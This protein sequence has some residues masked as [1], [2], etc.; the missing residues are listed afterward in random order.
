MPV[1]DWRHFTERFRAEMMQEE[2][3][4]IVDSSGDAIIGTS[5]EGRITSWNKAAAAMF[6]YTSHEAVGQSMQ[7]L[8]PQ[9]RVQEEMDLLAQVRGGRP[10]H[11]VETVRLRQDGNHIPVS[12][13]ISPIFNAGSL[14]TGISM[15]ARDI[16]ERRHMSE[17]ALRQERERANEA[18][19]RSALI[20]RSI[21]TFFIQLDT[22]NTI[23]EWNAAAE[24]IFSLSASETVG[25]R[26]TDLPIQWEW[27]VG[28]SDRLPSRR[29]TFRSFTIDCVPVVVPVNRRI[30][31]RV[32]ITTLPSST[33]PIVVMMGED[34]TDRLRVEAEMAQTQKLE[35]IGKLAAGIAH[36]INTPTQYIGDNT[37]FLQDSF[38]QLT[39]VLQQYH[40][41]IMV[42]KDRE[43]ASDI[44]V[45]LESA[46]EKADLK[47]MLEEIPKAIQQS[48]EGIERVA[49]I[50]RAMKEFAHPDQGQRT[51]TDLNKAIQ[52]TI[53]VARNEWKYVADVA[54]DL[55]P[56]LPLVPC[57]VGEFNQVILNLIVNAT[58]AIV[59][60]RTSGK[61]TITVTTRSRPS[62][63]EVRIQDTGTGIP[64]DIR[65]K[66]FD[67]FFTTKEVGKG[68]GQGLAIARSVIV[69]KHG[70]SLTFET[71]LGVGTTFVVSLPTDADSP[72][73]SS[74]SEAHEIHHAG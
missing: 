36:E 10:V 35:S 48:L 67:P 9:E 41:V 40:S 44:I 73:R 23:L 11:D 47:Y 22:T 18:G 1:E 30:V 59:D 39:V 4:A 74:M 3:A 31:L 50:V 5:L 46:L 16:T 21:D 13:T 55:E 62:S 32:S 57:Y 51:L 7:L 29:G 54:V 43:L 71:E 45:D 56:G 6:G 19:S 42:L 25:R 2:L 15:I 64:A 72:L 60:R 8:V 61:G 68:T 65:D 70:G 20:L 26:L 34:I 14:M 38:Q 49:T 12:L 17:L 66:I 28:T 58:H 52:S 33:A 24:R 27:N 69:K 63:V 53:T 37:R